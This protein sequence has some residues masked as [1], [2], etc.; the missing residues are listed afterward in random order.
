[1]PRRP[2]TPEDVA[3]FR[4][5]G[6]PQ[7]SPDASTVAWIQTW[8]DLE[9]DEPVSA[10][11]IAP[12]D[13]S[14][15]PRRFTSG[16]HDLSARWSPDGD[17]LAYLSAPDG[18][19]A[20][21]LAPLAGGEPITVETS[22]PVKGFEWSPKGD[23]LVV[24]V[25]VP[26]QSDGGHSPTASH[27]PRV[28]KG[29]FNRLDGTGWLEGRDHLFLY[30]VAGNTISRLTSGDFDHASPAW[31]PDGSI[32][33]F[34]SDRSRDRDDKAFMGDIWT[35]EVDGRRRAP[36]RVATDLAYPQALTYSPDGT[37][38]AFAGLLGRKERAARD[39]RLLVVDLAS[40]RVPEIVAPALDRPTA[41]TPFGRAA[42]EWLAPDE[43]VFTVADG[44]RIAIRRAR[45]GEHS[46][47]A[48][49]DD[50]RQVHALSVALAPAGRSGH[51]RVAFSSAWVDSPGEIYVFEL[52]RR[53]SEPL[54]VS[55]ASEP[56]NAVVRLRPAE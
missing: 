30:D 6:D 42:Y 26:D 56:L 8:L 28:V 21:K 54:R 25:N 51:Q 52:G 11:F 23:R 38:L 14:G 35:V 32:I 29:L 15:E 19:P 41:Y 40:D 24:V 45:L 10:V 18:P 55:R 50:D 9:R 4:W 20:L 39:S 44:G 49:L 37:R 13:G 1:M 27:A 48:V 3:L 5:A 16:P 12:A 2:L 53:A 36:R 22:G 43:L 46:T 31:S 47:R 17:Y 7:L 33:A 34:V